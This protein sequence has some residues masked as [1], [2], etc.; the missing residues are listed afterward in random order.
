MR[1]VVRAVGEA[2]RRH[3]KI[4]SLALVGAVAMGLLLAGIGATGLAPAVGSSLLMGA[5]VAVVTFVILERVAPAAALVEAPP[6]A[7]PAVVSTAIPGLDEDHETMRAAEVGWASRPDPFA[8]GW[9]AAE[10]DPATDE[11]E[12]RAWEDWTSTLDTASAAAPVWTDEPRNL[13]FDFKRWLGAPDQDTVELPVIAADSA[14]VD[15]PT[16]APEISIELPATPPA[17]VQVQVPSAAQVPVPRAPVVA[18]TPRLDLD[19]GPLPTAY[20][21]FTPWPDAPWRLAL[22]AAGESGASQVA[23]SPSFFEQVM[24]EVRAIQLAPDHADGVE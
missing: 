12:L 10:D 4:A 21:E 22:P 6:T 23:P 13:S 20:P 18:S 16:P 9:G 8:V 19:F 3:L 5:V 7:E 2:R 24:G 11:L 1:S 14:P 15:D 17:P